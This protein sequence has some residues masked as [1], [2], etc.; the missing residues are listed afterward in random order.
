MRLAALAQREWTLYLAS[1]VITALTTAWALKIWR[2]DWTVPFFYQVDAVLGAAGFKTVIET[3]WYENQPL[4]S[5]PHGQVLYDWKIADNFGYLFEKFVAIFTSDP[6]LILNLY[7]VLG[8]LFAALTAVWFFRLVGVS[9]VLSVTLSVLYAIAPYHFARNEMHLFLAAYFPIPLVMGIVYLAMRGRPIWGRRAGVVGWRAWIFGPGFF[10]ALA[11]ALVATANSYYA[12]FTVLLIALAGLFSVLRTHDWRRFLGAVIAGVL[13]VLV[14]LANMLP[15]IIYTWVNG[16]N[17]AAVVRS[18]PGVEVYSLKF[19]QLILPVPGHR[20]GILRSIRQFYTD[21]FPL[22][23]EDPS[24]GFIAA[25]GF[26]ALLGLGLYFVAGLRRGGAS[27]ADSER[28]ASLGALS[29]L[30]IFAFL[31]ATVGGFS[32]I[33]GFFTSDLRGWNRLSIVI[34]LF[35]LAAVGLIVDAALGRLGR[36]F[37]LRPVARRILA[38]GLAVVLLGVGYL[39]Q[40]TPAATPDYAATSAAFRQ[41]AA[42]VDSIARA[43]GAHASIVQLPYRDFPESAAVN[44]VPD[45]DQLKPYL[46]SSTLHW[47]GGGVKGRPDSEWVTVLQALPADALT[48]S[49]AAAGFDGILVDRQSYGDLANAFVSELRNQ[50]GKPVVTSKDHRYEFYS[51]TPALLAVH[52]RFTDE[53]V[54]FIGTS[55][56]SPVLARMEPD[57]QIGYDAVDLVKPYHPQILLENPRKTGVTIELKF[58]VK[59]NQGPSTLRFTKPDG[60]YVDAYVD[61]V[62]Q[63]VNIPINVQPGRSFIGISVVTGIP[64]PAQ[65]GN[66]LENLLISTKDVKLLSLLG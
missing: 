66:T 56:A 29:A 54:K 10:T 58:T 24:L 36:R 20:L 39:D 42:L 21:T 13:V 43:V 27:W 59:N 53:Q 16:Q 57:V 37:S 6:Y 55:I 40:V 32:T 63:T 7:Y 51:L 12:F 35:A 30:T 61:S 46:H 48:Q 34:A 14:T 33:I 8:F 26:L 62:G 1:G 38:G 45:T 5:A 47:T 41:D 60:T 49:A 4:L 31:L 44:G 9:R 2:A 25:F 11:L 19:A 64:F 3:G 23:S 28:R 65:I 50:L 22:P 18:P 17:T 52:K 15:N